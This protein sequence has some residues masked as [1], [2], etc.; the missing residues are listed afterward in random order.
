MPRSNKS[1]YILRFFAHKVC[2][3]YFAIFQPGISTQCKQLQQRSLIWIICSKTYILLFTQ[4]FKMAS[5]VKLL[6]V[7]M[8]SRY[9]VL[10]PQRMIW[11]E[12]YYVGLEERNN[13]HCPENG[14]I[15]IFQRRSW[16][17]LITSYCLEDVFN[18]IKILG[19]M[20]FK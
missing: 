19:N 18:R 14:A 1:W 6:E 8:C 11:F 5:K 9:F 10:L 17:M 2:C 12:K 4:A 3:Y 7:F 16:Y 15:Y 13:A 20:N